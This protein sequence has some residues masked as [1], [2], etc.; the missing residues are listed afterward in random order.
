MDH[1]SVPFLKL[2]R[3]APAARVTRRDDGVQI[4]ECPRAL[5]PVARH[6]LEFLDRAAAA[7]PDRVFLAQRGPG[8]GPGGGAWIELTYARAAAQTDAVAQALLDRGLAGE[9]IMILSENSLE[10]ALLMLGAMRM[11]AVAVPVSPAY[12]LLSTDLAK[13]RS[14]HARVA[15]RLVFAQNGRMYGR[16]L[17]ALPLDGAE[18][19]CAAAPP[20]GMAVTDFAALLAPTPGPGVAAAYAAQDGDTMAKILFTSGSTGEPK[21]VINTQ[22]MLC[23]VPAMRDNMSE[24]PDPARP[25]VVLDWLPW[26]HT[27]GGNVVFDTV[28]SQGGTLYI[29]GGRPTPELFAAT[30]ANLRDVAPTTFSSVPAAYAML[31]PVLEKDEALCRHFFS[32]LR[33]LTYGGAA[34][35]QDLFDRVQALAVRTIG[36]RINFST[37][38]GATETGG[39]E[40]GVHWESDVTGQLGL[41]APATVLKLV[42]VADKFEVR[43]KGPGVMPGY[44]ADPARTAAAFDEEGFFKLGDAVR[45]VDP[46]DPAQG[47]AFAGRVAEDFKLATGTWVHAGALRVTLLAS[48]SPLVQ[49]LLLTGDGY[50]GAL[51]WPNPAALRALCPDLPADAPPAALLAHENVAAALGEALRRHNAAHDH[52]STRVER[53]LLMAEPPSIDAGEITDKRYVNQRAALERRADLVAKLFA[54]PPGEGVVVA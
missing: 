44:Y 53:I 35:P 48:L 1:H 3:P 36:R 32:R 51:A 18:V 34:L 28:M 8:D 13:L 33:S 54:E 22:R 27:Y 40:M 52:S 16:A 24:P 6:L 10:H 4:V 5:G 21:G 37:G 19:V 43:F 46:D 47:L 39:F 2:E 20:E 23:A 50:L 17:A 31:A 45:W 11:G 49:D 15:P 25:A 41:P 9:R 14:I 7:H 12:S 29:D 42:P 30:I 38:H 26:H